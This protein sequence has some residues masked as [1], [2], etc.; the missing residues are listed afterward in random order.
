MARQQFTH[1]TLEH[2]ASQLELSLFGQRVTRMRERRWPFRAIQTNGLFPVEKSVSVLWWQDL[3]GVDGTGPLRKGHAVRIH[4]KRG[5]TARGFR[6]VTGGRL[7]E[8]GDARSKSRASAPES[9]GCHTSI[10][11]DETEE[12]LF[13]VA[14]SNIL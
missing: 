3:G 9:R 14:C 13:E 1:A 12:L 2:L 6:E 11:A 4:G 5:G 10:G 8:R 7:R